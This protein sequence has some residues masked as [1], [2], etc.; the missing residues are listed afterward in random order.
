MTSAH[1]PGPTVGLVSVNVGRVGYLGDRRGSMVE[2]GCAKRKV[3][4]AFVRVSLTNLAGDQ[5]A[6]LRAHGG[7]DKAVY[8]YPVDHIP[9]WT[10]ELV[11][12]PPFGPGSFGENLTVTGW[13]EE[14][15]KIG[16]VWQW[17]TA[18]LQI[19]QPRYPCFKLSMATGQTRIVKLMVTS[20]RTGWYLR[21]LEEG[22]GPTDGQI[23]LRDRSSRSISVLDAHRA[24]L[25]DADPNLI[26]R[27]VAE[28]SLSAGLRAD[29][30]HELN[31]TV[32][33]LVDVVGDK[34]ARK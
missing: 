27:V 17:G 7:P 6:D 15:V 21:V 19:C 13:T 30:Q 32:R 33:P 4:D 3:S 22:D 18:T 29:L 20:G 12:N 9:W 8:A 14:T 16:D 23:H 5:Q 24:R 2:S 25:P 11:P 1:V 10:T 31:I 28:E 26:Q 34:A